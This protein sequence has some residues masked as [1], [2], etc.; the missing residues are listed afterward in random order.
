MKDRSKFENADRSAQRARKRR[1][2]GLLIPALG[3]VFLATP[4]L[5]AFT[6]GWLETSAGSAIAFVLGI[7]AILIF[8][9]FL[10]SKYM[11][12]GKAGQ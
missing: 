1:D 6:K 5:N 3:L 4:V 11:T 7:W 10:L 12:D 9:A 8:A 2:L